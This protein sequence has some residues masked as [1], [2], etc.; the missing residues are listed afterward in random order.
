MTP[1]RKRVLITGAAG[2][3]GTIL[4][5][6]LAGKYDVAALT[7][8]PAGFP[9]YVADIT[10]LAS[11]LPAFHRI[12]AVIHL[13]AAAKLDSAWADVLASNIIGTYN[14]FEAARQC[15]VEL[16]VF[17]SSNHV[18]GMYE[19]EW[20][21]GAYA[22]DD[23][24]L[25]DESSPVRPD[26]LYGVSKVFGEALGRYY[27]DRYGLRAICLR[28]GSVRSDDD[29]RSPTVAGYFSWLTL[30]AEESYDR[31]RATWLS[32]RDCAQLFEKALE[33]PDRFAV[34]YGTSANPRIIWDLRKAR[35]LGF[36]P[37][38]KAPE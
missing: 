15:G 36:D 20:G 16:V 24:R 3:L 2:R 4:R 30:T 34:A 33:A 25:I 18:T 22:L 19:V 21:P 6:H 12:D 10:D 32:K 17:A 1:R 7:H 37:V 26:S 14:V 9:S 5:A 38:D 35:E 27:V 31:L 28:I 23:Q 8:K 13:A 11:L 29:P